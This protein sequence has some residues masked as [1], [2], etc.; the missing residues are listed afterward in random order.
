MSRSLKLTHT[1]YM[2]SLSLWQIILLTGGKIPTDVT[3]PSWD[4]CRVLCGS[5]SDTASSAPVDAWAVAR[6][7]GAE[8]EGSDTRAT[9]TY[10]SSLTHKHTHIEHIL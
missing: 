1:D 5:G 9:R 10:V 4:K 7:P 6:K 2:T 8:R 3:P